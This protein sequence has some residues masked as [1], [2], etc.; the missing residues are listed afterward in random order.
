MPTFI[1]SV[2]STL[3][4]L[5]C[6]LSTSLLV[7][8][9]AHAGACDLYQE[10]S[11]VAPGVFAVLEGGQFEINDGNPGGFSARNDVCK[12]NFKG[13]STINVGLSGY[14]PPKKSD[15]GLTASDT[16][17]DKLPLPTFQRLWTSRDIRIK[18]SAPEVTVYNRKYEPTDAD[19]LY[20]GKDTFCKNRN[21]NYCDASYMGMTFPVLTDN[22]QPYLRMSNSQ[23]HNWDLIQ[24]D[25]A[26]PY[27]LYFSYDKHAEPYM[28]N[29][30]SV[31]HTHRV[32]FEPGTYFIDELEWNDN[33]ILEVKIKDEAGTPLGDGSGVAKIHIY[34]GGG[35]RFKGNGACINVEKCNPGN[36]SGRSNT[37]YPERLHFYVHTGS[38]HFGDRIQVAAGVYVD[39]GSFS[40]KANSKTVF[41]GEAVAKNISVANNAGVEFEYQPTRMFE[42]LYDSGTVVEAIVKEGFYSLAA[43]AA[44]RNANS[45]DLVYIPYQ[46]DNTTA[47]GGTGVTGHLM[48]F[49]LSETGKTSATSS[50][51]ANEEMLVWE[52]RSRLFSTDASGAL[53]RMRD[54]DSSAFQSSTLSHTEIINYTIDPNFSTGKY[55]AGRD[56]S[57]MMGPPYKTR[58]VIVESAGIVVFHSDDGFAYGVDKKSGDIKW[59][60]IPRPLIAQLKNYDTFY[61]THPMHGQISTI[62]GSSSISYVVGS[63]Q[64]GSLHYA[65]RV[66]TDGKLKKQSWLDQT[67]G[68][69]ASQPVTFQAG[70]TYYALYVTNKTN[71]VVRSLAYNG[72]TETLYNLASKV[73]EIT[74]APTLHQSF[75][76][77]GSTREQNI[78]L[79]FGDSSGNTYEA[80]LVKA[81]SLVS[82]LRLTKVGNVGT[83]SDVSDPVLFT[84]TATLGGEDFVTVQTEKR[85]KVFARPE[86]ASWESRWTSY[87]SGSGYWESGSYQAESD[88][89]SPKSEHIQKLS[90]NTK[91]TDQVE[92][93]ESVI[94]LPVQQERTS[95]CDA[96]YY[97]YQLGDGFFPVN[98]L[99]LK[100]P[101]VDNVKIGTGL[102]FKPT[103]ISL[104]GET[105]VQG[106]SERNSSQSDGKT[107]LGLDDPFQFT[108]SNQGIIDWREL[109]DD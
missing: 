77:D 71:I 78:T 66:G 4:T 45:G 32:I 8:S 42:S 87:V 34:D 19:P 10:A 37:Q 82:S 1:H 94:F 21:K 39:Q 98:T 101:V 61:K 43:P 26:S 41:I 54:M 23:Y 99:R 47:D 105:T 75:D 18:N 3:V 68:G 83:L 56:S 104:D 59:G 52:R 13:S 40:I 31:G 9:L 86:G 6:L 38:L 95:S 91:I 44:P 93:A 67:P 11:G 22:S 90:S 88:Y 2:R 55:L 106:H 80:P 50:W 65:L 96:L 53:K 107:Q 33:A 76:L 24:A 89:S 16:T 103:V 63:A 15:C 36:P 29:K 30:L 100:N 28:F 62:D 84:Q 81:S 25:A 64:S 48:A 49:P 108:R 85:L 46:T 109:T 17:V 73:G 97:L 92:I 102:A 69:N 5:S 79:Y 72:Y 14:Y 51:D 57:N 12:V 27:D 60:Y 7:S 35:S 20:P 70:S 74:S 58:P